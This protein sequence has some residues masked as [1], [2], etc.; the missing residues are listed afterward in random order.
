MVILRM[1]VTMCMRMH[2]YCGVGGGARANITNILFTV[3]E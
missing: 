1:L 3:S 2:G